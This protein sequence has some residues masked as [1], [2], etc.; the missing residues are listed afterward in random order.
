MSEATVID[1][2]PASAEPAT[3]PGPRAFEPSRSGAAKPTLREAFEAKAA[4]D[5]NRQRK[6]EPP[7]PQS[8]IPTPPK[9]ADKP[10]EAKADEKPTEAKVDA[11]GEKLPPGRP[12]KPSA[13]DTWKSLKQERDQYKREA[14]EMRSQRVPEQERTTLTQRMEQIQKRNE[15]L[16]NH[17]RF[18]DYERSTE[19]KEKY[20]KPYVDMLGD[21]TTFLERIPVLDPVTQTQRAGSVQDIYS[22]MNMNP[23]EQAEA[24]EAM[25]GSR[26]APR[27]IN[28]VEKVR[29]KLIARKKALDEAESNGKQREQQQTEQTTRQIKAFEGK[30]KEWYTAAEA[31]W[32]K[33]P[34]AKMFDKITREDGK[35]LTPDEIEHNKLVDKGVELSKWVSKHPR[36]AATEEEAAKIVRKQYAILKRAIHFAP[37]RRL[38]KATAKKL[39][40]A[41]KELEGYRST[42]PSTAGRQPNGRPAAAVSSGV[43]GMFNKYAGR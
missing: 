29:D 23:V 20:D 17:L 6:P 13:Q 39:A 16:E 5:P 26:L 8:A 32:N 10:V 3:T 7:A 24:A 9:A 12:P 15:E 40:A 37:L 19:F 41:E 21:A 35:E 11:K 38:Y 36:N 4:P 30:V 1:A 27:V 18:K 33:D 25:F 2:P 28:E 22:L 42:T 43:K 31:E 34:D 14:E